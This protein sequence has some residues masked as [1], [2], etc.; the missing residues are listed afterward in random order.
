MPKSNTKPKTPAKK[1]T[2]K[3]KTPKSKTVKPKVTATPKADEPKAAEPNVDTPKADTPKTDTPKVDTPKADASPKVAQPNVAGSSE[4]QELMQEVANLQAQHLQLTKDI[5]TNMKSFHKLYTK[6][7]SKLLKKKVKD[8]NRAKRKPSGF[9]IPTLIN[10]KLSDFMGVEK[11]SM[12]TRT[13]VTK[14]ITSYIKENNLSKQ[15]NKRFFTPDD[16]LQSL[17]GPLDS[18]VKNKKSGL[19]DAEAGY[20]YFNLQKY[21]SH[22]F[23]KPN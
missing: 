5:N 3:S 14:K 15:E 21:I 18:V 12:V 1:K 20:S 8:P 17:L 2:P 22:N 13:Q 19:T 11:G 23:I 6:E 16:K 4:I 9:A 7:N 10:D